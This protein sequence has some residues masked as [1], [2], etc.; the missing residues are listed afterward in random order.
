AACPFVVHKNG[1]DGFHPSTPNI[2]EPKNPSDLN[3]NRK[4]SLNFSRIFFLLIKHPG[5]GPDPASR[6]D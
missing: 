2:I 6:L 3:K 4:K 1:V 5:A